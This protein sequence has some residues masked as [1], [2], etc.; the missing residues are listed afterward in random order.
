MRRSSSTR[1]REM[2]VWLGVNDGNMEEGSLRCDANVSVRPVGR[3]ALGTKAEVKNLNSFRFLQ[4]ALE[5]EIDRQIDLVREGGARRA[6]NAPVGLR[7]G[8]NRV[9]AQQ[10]RGARLPVLPRAGSAA[11]RR[12]RGTPGSRFAA[13]CPSCP[14]HARARFVAAYALS[15]YRRR[16]SSRSRAPWPTYFEETVAAGAPPQAGQQLDARRAGPQAEEDGRRHRVAADRAGTARRAHRADRRGAPSAARLRKDV[17]EKMFA[18][19]RTAA[20]IVRDEGLT[21]IDD[22]SQLVATD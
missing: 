3:R 21:Q 8:S 15:P 14:R 4:K 18:S 19:G 7:R 6:G 9:D 22:E 1:L 12:G 2:L 17:F 5:Y 13:R 10:G 20:D 16:D 11:G